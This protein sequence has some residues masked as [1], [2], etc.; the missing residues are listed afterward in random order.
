MAGSIL[1][2]IQQIKLAD[3]LDI[4]AVY[5]ALLYVMF[6]IRGTRAVQILQGVGVV[7]IILLLAHLLQF[8]TL[9]WLLNWFLVSLAVVLPIIFQ[10]ELR[11]ALMRLGQQGILSATTMSKLDKTELVPLIDELAFAVYSLGQV[12]IGA[13][14]VLEQDTGLQEY[15]E[16]GQVIEGLVSAKL[17][18]SL[19]HP[20]TPLHDGAVIIRGRRIAEAAR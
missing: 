15:V 2:F 1:H 5:G 3:V 12:R 7:L 13:L 9:I 19:F 14:I 20:K 8:K 4:L 17:L 11:R 18:I 10:P 6:A 16:Q